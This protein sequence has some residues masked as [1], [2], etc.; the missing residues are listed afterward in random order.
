MPIAKTENT[1][2][3]LLTRWPGDLL[4]LISGGLIFLSLAPY[5]FWP[6]AI[7]ASG[8]FAL[9]LNGLSNK[10]AWLRSFIFGLGMYSS[11]VSWVYISIHD[12]G[13]APPWLAALMTFLFVAFL[14]LVFS[15][16]FYF[17]QRFLSRSKIS[18]LLGF[19]AI[20]VLGEWSR[21]WLLTG[22]PW[23]F[24]GYG[25]SDTWLSGWAPIA[26]VYALSFLVVLT[27]TALFSLRNGGER[28]IPAL[29][30]AG[31]LL[32]WLAGLGLKHVEWTRYTEADKRSVSI[33]QPN[34]PLELKW[35]PYYRP[36]I[37]RQLRE[38]TEPNWQS[39][40]VLW[41]E[42]AIPLM[43]NDADDFIAELEALAS[44]HG[45]A[46][47]SGILFDDLEKN[48]YYN[49]IFGV[50]AADNIYFK[51][52]LVPFGEYVPME[53]YLRGLIDFFDLPNSIIHK[54]PEN[55]EGIQVDGYSIAPYICYEIVYPD[56]V[57]KNLED[58]RLMITISNDAWFGESIGPLQHF[59]MA[60]MRAL[61]NGRY[62]IRGTNTGLSGIISHKGEIVLQGTPFIPEAI[63]GEVYLTQGKTPFT[64]TRSLPIIALSFIFLLGAYL[65]RAKNVTK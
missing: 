20:W 50:G 26:G 45:T 27:G 10:L 40:I 6:V 29:A 33:V 62:L 64:Y 21:S 7:A 52:R 37:M 30:L 28:K 13:Y 60:R 49:S 41:P 12:F 54:G 14:A 56:L 59:E 58:A 23:L 9:S 47:I 16:P 57:A 1:H 18:M 19:P 61:E 38:L 53:E 42:A 5:N 46:L 65:S 15:I 55:Q 22:F 51:Q 17:Y 8:I 32:L 43:Y 4:S 48:K 2:S 39:D 44:E 31:V 11:G 24:L 35:N 36:A 34:I 25:H 3:P 63:T